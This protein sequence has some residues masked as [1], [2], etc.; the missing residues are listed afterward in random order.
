MTE[1]EILALV[2]RRAPPGQGPVTAATRLDALGLDSL[3][4][5][6]LLFDIEEAAGQAIPPRRVGEPSLGEELVTA[7]DVV[8]LVRSLG[9]TVG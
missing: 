2:R 6:E 3:R 7:G 1:A 9:A 8:R 5:T 4:M